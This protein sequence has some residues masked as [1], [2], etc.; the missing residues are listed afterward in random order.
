MTV[1]GLLNKKW[2]CLAAHLGFLQTPGS[3]RATLIN[4]TQYC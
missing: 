2:E 1:S 3:K 4:F